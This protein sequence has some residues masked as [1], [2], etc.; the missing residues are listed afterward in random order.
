[1]FMYNIFGMIVAPV[2]HD[3]HRANKF[4]S[5]AEEKEV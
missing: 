4:E 5:S 3:Y 1:M 2:N